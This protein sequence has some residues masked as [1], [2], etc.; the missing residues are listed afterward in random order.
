MFI[1]EHEYNTEWP[2]QFER[3]ET[4]IVENDAMLVS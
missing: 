4:W 3:L 1:F 2:R